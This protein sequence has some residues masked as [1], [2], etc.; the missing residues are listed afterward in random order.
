MKVYS[1]E[2]FFVNK[3]DLFKKISGDATF[4]HP[5]DTIYG[6]GCNAAN[7]EAVKDLRKIKQQFDRAFSVIAPSKE[8]I[9]ENC[10]VPEEHRAQL[11]KLPGPFTFILNLR[12][13]NVVA[14][15]TNLGRDNLGV[16]IPNHWF[17]EV[18]TELNLPIVTSSANIVGKAPFTHM[19][20]LDSSISKSISFA[21]YEGPKK[22]Q[23]STIIDLT[24]K[25]PSTLR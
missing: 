23:P 20:D 2:E 1:K 6:L 3:K 18:A 12:R 9:L 11:D 22:G 7:E 4:I 16:R 17:S 24:K 19:E 8:W 25:E 14:N 5:T 13:P 15:S 10:E 21:V